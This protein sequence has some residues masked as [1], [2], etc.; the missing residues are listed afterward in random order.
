[1]RHRNHSSVTPAQCLAA[2]LPALAATVIGMTSAPT[3]AAACGITEGT[4]SGSA[5]GTKV[6]SNPVRFEFSD[7]PY[8]GVRFD[9]C[10]NVITVHYG[11]YSSGITHYNIRYDSGGKATAFNPPDKQK[12]A[13]PGAA[14]VWTLSADPYQWPG[15]YQRADFMV[16]ACRRGSGIFSSSKCTRWSPLVGV[17]AGPRGG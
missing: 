15:G 1:M 5:P 16:Q 2:C 9:S 13:A 14:R 11:G 8:L 12:E 4:S 10:R 7:S 3:A 6:G 17:P